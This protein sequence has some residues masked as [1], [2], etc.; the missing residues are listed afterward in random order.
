VWPS[1]DKTPRPCCTVVT[2]VR[3]LHIARLEKA[4][5]DPRLSTVLKY[6]TIVLGG[7]LVARLLRDLE[8]SAGG[9]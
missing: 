3:V 1:D 7:V 4:V 2:L 6:A 9:E 5:S 8:R